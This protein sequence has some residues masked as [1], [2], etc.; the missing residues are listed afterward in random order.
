MAIKVGD[1][2]VQ[3]GAITTGLDTA[4]A[5]ISGKVATMGASI[6]SAGT[7]MMVGITAPLAL[8]GAFSLKTAADYSE[9]MASVKAVTNATTE[10]FNLLDEAAKYLGATTRY[11]AVEVA[12]A[13]KFM[14]MTGM[15][16]ATILESVDDVLLLAAAGNLEMG[17]AADIVTNIMAGFNLEASELTPTVDTLVKAF[18]SANVDL[19]MLGESMKYAGP[20]ANAYGMTLD[21]T[22]AIVGTLGNAGIQGS[23]AGTTL[24]QILLQLTDVTADL[25]I[26]MYDAQGNMRP[27]ID[28]LSDIEDTGI[29]TTEIIDMFGARAGPGVAVLLAEGTDALKDFTTELENTGGTAQ[30]VAD[31]QMEGIHGEIIKLKSAFEGFRIAIGEALIPILTPLIEKLTNLFRWFTDL[32]PTVKKLLVVFGGI[33]AAIG[34]VLFVV[35]KL[36]VFLA[37]L[38]NIIGILIGGGGIAGLSASFPMLGGAIMALLGPIGI[39]VAAIVGLGAAFVIAYKKSE[40]FRDIVKSVVGEIKDFFTSM[41]NTV[42]SV[43][44]SMVSAIRSAWEFIKPYLIE[45]LNYI[46][47]TISPILSSLLVLFRTVWDKIK[48]VVS[49][50][51]E[52]IKT[53]VQTNIAVIQKLWGMF[54]DDILSVA[55]AVWDAIKVVIETA[56]NV[57]RGIIDTIT[58]LINGDWETAW[59]NIKGIVSTIVDGIVTIIKTGLPKII[60]AVVQLGVDIAQGII[61]GIGDLGGK[62]WNSIKGGLSSAKNKIIDFFGISSPSK[63]MKEIGLNIGQGLVEGIEYMNPR[64]AN[65]LE[66]MIPGGLSS[67]ILSTSAEIP[68]VSRSPQSI[69]VRINPTINVGQKMTQSEIDTMMDGW[70]SS[71]TKT[72]KRKGIYCSG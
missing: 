63:V 55:S 1:A 52:V 17:T 19:N 70:V 35:G 9:A 45:A 28:I 31:T 51:F 4:L 46:Y 5:G 38:A 32:S 10:E 25:G 50:V 29:A 61:D 7:S 6:A 69:D 14:G 13:M 18:T 26:E 3:I 8:V 53:V 72:L 40:K 24:R 49:A 42:K 66:T 16:T 64:I 44:S 67:S 12:E 21:E 59:E 2:F 20:V 39:I 60:K 65:S 48:T 62:I 11:S 71:A 68:T 22:A 54:G 23:M 30:D 47:N 41:F 57:I 33:A 58:A 36:M 37:P 56:M 27:V 43:M 34:P 15:D